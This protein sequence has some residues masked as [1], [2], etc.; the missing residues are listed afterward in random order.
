MPLC[1]AKLTDG[2]PCPK[3]VKRGHKYCRWHDPED[4][5]WREIFKRL[6]KGGPDEITDIVLGL[7]EEHPEHKLVLPEQDGQRAHLYHVD[8]SREALDK[9]RNRTGVEEPPWW[10]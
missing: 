9:R 6:E 4:K 2:E 10:Y 5:S 8:L 7:I 1:K 3:T